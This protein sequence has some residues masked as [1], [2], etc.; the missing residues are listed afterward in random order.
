MNK[1]INMK[2]IVNQ[3]IKEIKETV[4]QDKVLLGISGGVDSS[5]V[6]V[7]VSKAIGDQLTCMFV[8]H[9]LLRKG[10]AKQVMDDFERFGIK[11]IKIDA[12]DKFL[13]LLKGIVDPESKRKII[14]KAFIDVFDEES[15]KLGDY[16]F[17]AQ[18]TILT[19]IIES[20]TKDNKVIKSHH[21]VGGLPEDFNFKLL[22]PLKDLYKDQVRELGLAMD[23]PEHLIF[24]QPFPGPGLAIRV[25]GDITEEKL[26]IVRD[27]DFILREE[28]KMN[29]LDRKIWQYFTVL[30][31]LKTVGIKN[32]QRSYD[33]TV[34]IRAVNSVDGMTS[35]WAR[36]PYEVLEIIS[37]RM[38]NEVE[39]CSRVVL[40]VTSKPPSTIEW[41]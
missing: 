20:K 14:G 37:G 36:I 17:L 16:K 28:I 29:N 10:E 6:A 5:V 25:I 9:G 38:V 12:R 8:D 40:D 22:E 1:D 39:G 11:V 13:N 24:R 32:N 21:N 26:R 4:K 3:K 33:Y 19:D 31:G 35:T 34:A 23:M 41:E 30:T 2:N 7:L 18:G 27:T 15:R